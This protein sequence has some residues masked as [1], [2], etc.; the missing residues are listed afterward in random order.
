[1]ATR[2]ESDFTGRKGILLFYDSGGK[3]IVR[4]VPRKGVQT[5]ASKSRAA[6]F[7]KAS[8][9]AKAVRTRLS[10]VIPFPA[11]N[12][13]QTRLIT[14]IFYW[15]QFGSSL[16]ERLKNLVEIR[17]FQFTTTG[18]PFS[19]RW[20]AEIQMK[21]SSAGILQIQIP[22]FTPKSTISSP[23]HTKLVTLKI[24]AA[25][26]NPE[27]CIA[28]GSDSLDLQ[29][30]YDRKKIKEQ[31][32]SFHFPIAKGSLILA[33]ASLDYIILKNRNHQANRDKAFM[34]AALIAAMYI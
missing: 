26:F 16:E 17:H 22:A 32:V 27:T 12:N 2:K 25:A 28:T 34:P 13:M 10:S 8:A 4:V 6:E 24:A 11:D 31:T 33:G 3:H 5:E 30:N 23:A 9:L 21:M 20:N 15:L 19:E 29:F 18:F 1:M 7:G 14:A